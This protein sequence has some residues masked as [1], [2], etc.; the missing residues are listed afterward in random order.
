MEFAPLTTRDF[1]P[2]SWNRSGLSPGKYVIM[3][4]V[5]IWDYEVGDIASNLT[6]TPNNNQFE[7]EDDRESL[8]L[9]LIGLGIAI[10]VVV[11]AFYVFYM[12]KRGQNGRE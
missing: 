4:R 12:S 2:W 9:A 5:V 6:W 3:S 11:T 8:S 1:G 7:P 10:A